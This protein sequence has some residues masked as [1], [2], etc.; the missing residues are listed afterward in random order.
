MKGLPMA[1]PGT[2]ATLDVEILKCDPLVT[3]DYGLILP[4]SL[5]TS[6]ARILMY[7]KVDAYG[8]LRFE[9]NSAIMCAMNAANTHIGVVWAPLNRINNQF[10]SLWHF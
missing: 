9:L 3:S 5:F 4:S 8:R 2:L 7:M 10:Q 1:Y 6:S